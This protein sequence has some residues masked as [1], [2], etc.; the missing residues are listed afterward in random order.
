MTIEERNKIVEENMSLVGHV[1]EQKFMTYINKETALEWDDFF[2]A[3]CIGLINAAKKFDPE[4]GFC[5][6]TYAYPVIKNEIIKM[7]NNL[8]PEEFT[9][10]EQG[11]T[12]LNAEINGDDED[13]KCELIDLISDDT[14]LFTDNIE[15]RSS[16]LDVLEMI[17][18]NEKSVTEKDVEIFD[19]V[20]QGYTPE[21]ICRSTGY[22]KKMVNTR[23]FMMKRKI[24]SKYLDKF[25]EILAAA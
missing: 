17:R 23:I 1:I 6:S 5:F 7:L 20:L 9:E 16:Y 22:E 25:S 3:G 18:N 10:I 12:S 4:R 11:M 13:K 19:L 21:D 8:R 2:Q 15:F 14:A 24:K